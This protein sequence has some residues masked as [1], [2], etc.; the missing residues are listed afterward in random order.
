MKK[1]L[2][3]LLSVS[4]VWSGITPANAA[5]KTRLTIKANFAD[6]TPVKTWNL[7]CDKSGG[8]HPN[9]KEACALL[10]KK[11]LSLFKP[12]PKDAIC[13]M[14]YGGDQ[15][16]TVTG[17]LANRKVNATF[18][19]TN[20]CEIARYDAAAALFGNPTPIP[21]GQ[22]IRGTLLLNG[23]AVAGTVLFTDGKRTVSAK[24]TEQGFE[25]RLSDGTWTGSAG[26]GISCAPVTI[27]TPAPDAPL[28]ISC[29]AAK[30]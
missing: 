25:I 20:G 30:S 9:R 24:A 2:V 28:T 4:F 3:I 18:T 22:L 15:R 19:R 17:L 13:D 1:L 12:V 21:V 14:M 29:T 8:N 10:I 5:T 27:T 6:G 23:Q 7:I 11:G 26:V 16:V